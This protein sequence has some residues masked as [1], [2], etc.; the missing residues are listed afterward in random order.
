MGRASDEGVYRMTKITQEQF[1]SYWSVFSL[2]GSLVGEDTVDVVVDVAPE[3]LARLD[4]ELSMWP[5]KDV[6]HLAGVIGWDDEDFERV[7]STE[8][9][10]VVDDFITD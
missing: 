6:L 2:I 7:C 5:L 10:R 1:P 3:E 4:R 9:G 8:V